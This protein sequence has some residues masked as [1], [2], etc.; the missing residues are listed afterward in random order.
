MLWGTAKQTKQ[1]KTKCTGYSVG[2]GE[3]PGGEGEKILE[4]GAESYL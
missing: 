4:L 1:N 2:L 3:L